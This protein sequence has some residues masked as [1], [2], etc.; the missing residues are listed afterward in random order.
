MLDQPGFK[1]FTSLRY[2][3]ILN[4]SVANGLLSN[5]RGC[6]LY[7]PELHRQRLWKASYKFWPTV[8]FKELES[9]AAF[10]TSLIRAIE[11]RERL[12]ETYICPLKV[13]DKGFVQSSHDTEL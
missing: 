12:H 1:I 13:G 7:M 4:K 6:P 3:P 9:T 11:E 5:R 2:D 8:R 10:E